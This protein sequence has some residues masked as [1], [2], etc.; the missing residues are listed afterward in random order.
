MPA[1]LVLARV[2]DLAGSVTAQ[3]FLLVVAR[4]GGAIAFIP[5]PGMRNAPALPKIFLVL[6]LSLVLAPTWNPSPSAEPALPQTAL[7]FVRC[8]ASDAAFGIAA[9]VVVSWLSE[10]FVVAMQILGM[11][12][13]YA[14]ASMIDPTTEAD[15]GMLP[16]LAQL[17]GML[18]FF[19]AGLDRE[20]LRVFGASLETIPPGSFLI[21]SG[22]ADA[23]V[24]HTSAMLALAFR[25]ALPVV[26]LLFLVDLALALLGRLNQQLQLLTLAFPAKMLVSLVVLSSLAGVVPTL[27]RQASEGAL[28]VLWG[29]AGARP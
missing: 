15:S 5:M 8:L 3:S 10:A 6:A 7:S 14:Y 2:A 13:G 17:A 23:I 28:R 4:V 19:A 26:A 18:L 1:D 27:Y 21:S 12:A 29:M 24:R 25:L 20:V 22:S 11:Q 16:V 9:G